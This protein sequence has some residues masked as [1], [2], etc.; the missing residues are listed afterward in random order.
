MSLLERKQR[1]PLEPLYD[2]HPITGAA[3]EVFYA[4]HALARSF[5]LSGTGWAWWEC[6]NGLT[7]NMHPRGPFATSYGAYRNALLGAQSD[8]R[9]GESDCS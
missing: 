1:G 5:G 6:S 9:R 4:D 2:T 3:I 7:P 8:A